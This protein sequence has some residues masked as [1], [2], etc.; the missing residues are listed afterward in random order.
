MGALLTTFPSELH[1]GSPYLRPFHV[2]AAF[3]APSAIL[4]PQALLTPP[5]LLGGDPHAAG[6][7]VARLGPQVL[8]M[9]GGP[10]ARQEAPRLWSSAPEPAHRERGGLGLCPVSLRERVCVQQGR[11]L[12]KLLLL[13]WSPGGGCAWCLPRSC[14][15]PLRGKALPPL[16]GYSWPRAVCAGAVTTSSTYHVEIWPEHAL[17]PPLPSLSHPSLLPPPAQAPL[18]HL[19]TLLAPPALRPPAVGQESAWEG[20]PALSAP[21][22]PQGSVCGYSICWALVLLL[23]KTVC[24][25]YRPFSP[26]PPLPAPTRLPFLS[27]P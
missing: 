22:F 10:F 14:L 13:L 21:P 1:P 15:S 18:S 11:R 5:R 25:V 6:H 17:A 4:I 9:V 3:S 23:T 24:G 2:G 7:I 27:Q 8:R 26:D 12:C 16:R 19:C 20:M